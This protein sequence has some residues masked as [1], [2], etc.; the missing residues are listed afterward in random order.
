MFLVS[1][2]DP[3]PS[4]F[5]QRLCH[6]FAD[7]ITIGAKPSFFISLEVM[8]LTALGGLCLVTSVADMKICAVTEK[9]WKS[10]SSSR[11]RSD[12]LTDKNLA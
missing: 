3:L 7:S 9:S 1:L 6:E 2:G 12:T 5:S 8:D 10:R 11:P 4:S